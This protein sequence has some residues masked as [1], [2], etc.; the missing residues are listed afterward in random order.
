MLSGDMRRYNVL[1]QVQ[2]SIITLLTMSH[3][4]VYVAPIE[5]P[6]H[7]GDIRSYQTIALSDVV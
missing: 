6:H 2:Y 7:R 1:L 5:T 4:L 3:S